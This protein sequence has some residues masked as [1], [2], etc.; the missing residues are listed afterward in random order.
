MPYDEALAA[1]VRDELLGERG[2]TERKMFGG[3]GFMLD[4]NMAVAASSSGDLMVRADPATSDDWVDG[5]SVRPMEMR[6]RPM[7]GWLLVSVQS[8]EEDAALKTWVTRG[9]AYARSLPAK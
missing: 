7:T 3:L 5:E 6:G 9:L 8:L 1:R 2:V 4:G